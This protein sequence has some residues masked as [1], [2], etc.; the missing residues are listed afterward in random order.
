MKKWI[1]SALLVVAFNAG[2]AQYKPV[3][4]GSGL[5]FTIKNLGFDVTGTFGGFSGMIDFDPHNLTAAKFDVTLDAATINTDNSLRDEHL[6]GDSFFDVKKFPRI[7][8]ISDKVVANGKADAYKFTGQ[9]IIKGIS[10]P[11]AFPFIATPVTDG[12]VFKGGFK[13][14][15][16]DFKVGG[17]STVSDELSVVI[18]TVAKKV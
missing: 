1:V 9:L 11:V 10:R 8:L 7:Q 18:V 2:K 13:M 14:N 3:E 4:Q 16:K 15:R 5:I 6:K 12:Y 17:T